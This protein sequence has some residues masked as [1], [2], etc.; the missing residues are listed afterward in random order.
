MSKI[1]ELI[2]E[3]CPNGVE[4]KPLREIAKIKRGERITKKDI[5][6]DGEYPVMSGGVKPM[7]RYKDK[8]RDANTLTMSRKT[9]GQMMY[10]YRYIP[11]KRF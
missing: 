7:G 3:K 10:A 1:D 11:M 6:D 9:F 5:T 4:R 8:K 2:K